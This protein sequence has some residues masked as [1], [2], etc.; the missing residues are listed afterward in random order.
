MGVVLI[1]KSTDLVTPEYYKDE[2][3]FERE[4]N[5]QQNAIN[6]SSKLNIE[7]SAEGLTLRLDTPDEVEVLDISLYRSNSKEDDVNVESKGK[8]LFIERSKLKKGRYLLTAEWKAHE[9]SYQLRDT[10]WIQ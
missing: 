5:A 10:V 1:G 7:E 8:N 4:I 2:V 9:Q 3:L 6:N